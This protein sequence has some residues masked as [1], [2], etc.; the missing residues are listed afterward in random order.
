MTEIEYNKCVSMYADNV[1]RFIVKNLNHPENAKDIVQ[2]AFEKL[3]K[4]R[5]MVENSKCKSFLFTVAYNQMID[6]IRKNKR[7]QLVEN[8]ETS[9]NVTYQPNRNTQ[10]QLLIAL[11]RLNPTQKSLIMLKDYEGYNYEEIGAITGLNLSQVK[12]Y[13]HRARIILKDYLVSKENV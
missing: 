4:H 8:F 13:L 11:E 9:K 5:E 6:F 10:E 3:W 12:V 1:F 2:T 7:V